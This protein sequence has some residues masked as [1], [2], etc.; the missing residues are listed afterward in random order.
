MKY[1]SARRK[2]EILSFETKWMDLEGII[3]NE[4]NQAERDKY[5]NTVYLLYVESKKKLN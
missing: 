5:S 4:I 3:L 1:Y 2:K